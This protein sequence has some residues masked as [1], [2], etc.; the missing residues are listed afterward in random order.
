MK[1]MNVISS[2]VWIIMLSSCS[3]IAKECIQDGWLKE[4]LNNYHSADKI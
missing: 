1:S 3:F 4:S 2:I